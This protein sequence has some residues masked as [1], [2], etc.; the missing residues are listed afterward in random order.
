MLAQFYIQKISI[1][2]KQLALSFLEFLKIVTADVR[3]LLPA[4]SKKGFKKASLQ[5]FL[6]KGPNYAKFC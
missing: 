2:K 1:E 6:R 3:S 5:L 4:C